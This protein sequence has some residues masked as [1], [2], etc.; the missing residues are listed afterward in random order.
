MRDRR[1]VKRVSYR[2]G[3][4]FAED[5]PPRSVNVADLNQ[6]LHGISVHW[7]AILTIRSWNGT[8]HMGGRMG[9]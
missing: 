4:L 2:S 7:P 9:V 3:S 1:F 5:P 6:F 8:D